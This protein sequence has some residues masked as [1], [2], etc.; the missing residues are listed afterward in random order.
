MWS[1][2]KLAPDMSTPEILRVDKTN[3]SDL[4]IG[5]LFAMKYDTVPD[6]LYLLGK[7]TPIDYISDAERAAILG[8]TYISYAQDDPQGFADYMRRDHEFF[9]AI[10]TGKNVHSQSL[11]SLR[12]QNGVTQVRRLLEAQGIEPESA[13]FYGSVTLSPG[14]TAHFTHLIGLPDAQLLIV[15]TV[16]KGDVRSLQVG[17]EGVRHIAR[18]ILDAYGSTVWGV[19]QTQI[20]S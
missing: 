4:V 15:Q 2:L 9:D 13:L 5:G 11:L 17:P 20:A 14:Y 1:N 10:W 7:V 6:F 18:K 3:R 12:D 8:A 16:I 19:L